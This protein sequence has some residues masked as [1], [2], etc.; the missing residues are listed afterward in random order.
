MKHRYTVVLSSDDI[1][2]EVDMEL[3]NEGLAVLVALAAAMNKQ[4]TWSSD[5]RMHV[6]SAAPQEEANK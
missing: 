3:T 6:E 2:S 1:R 5:I 4:A